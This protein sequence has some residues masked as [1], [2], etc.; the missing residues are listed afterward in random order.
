MA[1]DYIVKITAQAQE[2][3]GEIARYIAYNL[4]APDT[5]LR[6]LD[7]LEKEIASLSRFPNRIALTEEEPWHSYGIHKIPVKNYLIYF[8][9]DETMHKVQVTAVVYG[10][11]YQMQQL[12]QMGL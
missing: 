8:W 4:Q 12:S 7:T 6:M 5:A 11:R 9:I 10:R 3:I 1:N 2:Q